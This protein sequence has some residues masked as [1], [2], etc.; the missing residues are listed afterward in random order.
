[1]VAAELAA[2]QSVSKYVLRETIAL[3]V[4]LVRQGGSCIDI[5][6]SIQGCWMAALQS[7]QV[8]IRSPHSFL[9]YLLS[10]CAGGAAQRQRISQQRK[11]KTSSVAQQMPLRRFKASSGMPERSS[12]SLKQRE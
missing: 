9:M 1:M 10:I 2:S 4:P 7:E 5:C 3:H 11:Y 8:F 12:A 6:S